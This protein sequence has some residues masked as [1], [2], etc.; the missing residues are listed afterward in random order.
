[1]ILKTQAAT[2]GTPAT[3]GKKKKKKKK[4]KKGEQATGDGKQN[5]VLTCDD[6]KQPRGLIG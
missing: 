1:M 2:N 4:N 6:V 5:Q 3:E